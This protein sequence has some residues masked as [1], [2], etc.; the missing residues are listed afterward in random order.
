[1]ILSFAFES[2]IGRW[3]AEMLLMF[4]L[5][6][7]DVSLSVTLQSVKVFRLLYGI[8]ELSKPKELAHYGESWRPSRSVASWYMW[9]FHELPPE[10]L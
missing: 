2:G 3:T 9:R 1:M 8:R 4:S 6:R 10:T 7:S 5:G